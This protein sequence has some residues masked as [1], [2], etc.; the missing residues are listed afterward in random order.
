MK[1]RVLTALVLLSAAGAAV[2]GPEAIGRLALS[3][4]IPALAARLLD[5][6][7]WR[8]VALYRSGRFAAADEAFRAA[9]SGSTYN[10]G[11]SL[12]RLGR[13]EEAVAYYDAVLFRNP[14]DREAKANRDLV[15]ILIDPV[16]GERRDGRSHIPP[17]PDPPSGTPSPPPSRFSAITAVQSERQRRPI[18]EVIS[19]AAGEEWL[20]TL[21]DEPGRYLKLRIAAEHERRRAM[22]LA[23]PPGDSPW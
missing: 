23:A 18:D 9:G 16:V 20:A 11:N 12:A 13:Y 5:D 15:A 8:G 7:A 22:G 4:G 3:A 14:E 17:A 2:A 1:L 19:V 21:R 10:R 6:P